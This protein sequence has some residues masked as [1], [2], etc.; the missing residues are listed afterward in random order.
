[1]DYRLYRLNKQKQAVGPAYV[2]EA[3]TDEDAI[4]EAKRFQ[5]GF[6]RELRQDSRIVTTLR[7]GTL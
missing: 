4:A 2:I 3:E 1:M 5:R 6:D 7:A